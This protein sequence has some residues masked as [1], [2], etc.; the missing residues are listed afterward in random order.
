MR[1]VINSYVKLQVRTV[2]IEDSFY[3]VNRLIKYKWIYYNP[4]YVL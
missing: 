4:F 1:A 2:I 3:L